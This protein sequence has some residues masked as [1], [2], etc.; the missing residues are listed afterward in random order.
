[1]KRAFTGRPTV[2][3]WLLLVGCWL[4]VVGWLLLVGCCWLVVVGWLVGLVGWV[5]GWV[6]W[7]VGWLAGWLV[8]SVGWLLLLVAMCLNYAATPMAPLPAT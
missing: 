7:L 1:M 6:G 2:V 5:G 3:G 4:V 8:G